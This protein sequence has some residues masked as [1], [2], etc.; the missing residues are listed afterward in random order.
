[1]ELGVGKAVDGA[2]ADTRGSFSWWKVRNV[3]VTRENIFKEELCS[4]MEQLK[5]AMKHL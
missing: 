2:A 3:L 5:N 4:V 1:M